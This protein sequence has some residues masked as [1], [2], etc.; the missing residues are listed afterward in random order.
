MKEKVFGIDFGTTNTVIFEAIDGNT[1]N[2]PIN[3]MEIIPSTVRY[4]DN[5]VFELGI[6]AQDSIFSVKRFLGQEQVLNGHSV[7]EIYGDIFKFFHAELASQR[8]S[9][10]KTVL[11]VPAYFN[12]RQRNIMKNAAENSGFKIL[13]ILSEPTAAIFAHNLLKEGIYGV[14]DFGGGTFDFS[15][16]EYRLGVFKVLKTGGDLSLGGDDIDEEIM[17]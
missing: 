4:N 17:S 6:N 11:T 13:K 10:L 3:N 2:V 15:I 7:E 5:N 12:E 9:I 16:V 14:Y 1:L 8:D